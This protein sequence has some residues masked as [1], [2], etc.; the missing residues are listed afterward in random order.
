[1]NN[2]NYKQ[3]RELVY[4]PK[5]FSSK[6]VYDMENSVSNLGTLEVQR[7]YKHLKAVSWAEIVNTHFVQLLFYV[8]RELEYRG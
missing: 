4:K 2:Y 8:K 1:M 7:L 5:L 6:L 3:M